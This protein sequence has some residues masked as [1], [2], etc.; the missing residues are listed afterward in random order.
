MTQRLGNN[1]DY[2]GMAAI[3]RL[4]EMLGLF[5][6]CEKCRIVIGLFFQTKDLRTYHEHLV[7]TWITTGWHRCVGN[8]ECLVS[9]GK[10][11]YYYSMALRN[12]GSLLEKCHVI[13]G[14]FQKRP[15][16]AS[17]LQL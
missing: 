16:G 11:Q 6:F 7:T 17:S 2:H 15:V 10:M 9:F 8:M 4:Y 5:F 12:V 3:Y 14:I 1:V 13:T